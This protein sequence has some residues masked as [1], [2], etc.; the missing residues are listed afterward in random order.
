MR[1]FLSEKGD[2]IYLKTGIEESWISNEVLVSKVNSFK[3]QH[4]VLHKDTV[5]LGYHQLDHD[6]ALDNPS[7]RN[8]GVNLRRY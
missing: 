7:N 5:L 2:L 1:N 8:K 3:S 4:R 6:M